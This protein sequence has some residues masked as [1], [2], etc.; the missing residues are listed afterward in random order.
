MTSMAVTT[1]PCRHRPARPAGKHCPGCRRGKVVDHVTAAGVKLPRQVVADAV[2]TVVAERPA[3][4]RS[5]AVALSSHPTALSVGAPPTVGLLVT[6]LIARGAALAVPACVVCARTGRPLTMTETGG[7]CQR[8][9]A[10]RNPQP[11]TRC[12][13]IKPVVGHTSDGQPICERCRRHERGHRPCG[14]CGITAS[15]AV[16]A[17]DGEPDV[18]VNCYRLPQ[19]ICSRCARRRPCLFADS[20]QP[21]CKPCAPRSTDAC[22]RCGRDRPPAVR[23]PEGPL[24]DTCYTTALRRRAHCARCGNLRRLVWPP[25]PDATTCTD[26]AGLPPSHTCADCGVE[27]KLYERNHCAACSLRRR[28]A[29]LLRGSNKEIPARFAG[30]HAAIV[31]TTAP[32]SALNWLRNGAGAAVL[33]EIAAG[34]LA[35]TH[36][37][38]DA[39]PRPQ[40]A[41][42]LRH[43]LVANGALPP[44]DEAVARTERWATD[45]IATIA[46]PED[47]RLAKAYTTWRVL[48]RLRRGAAQRPRPRTYTAVAH[49][50]LRTAVDFLAWLADHSL[51]LADCKQSDVDLWLET[52]PSAGSVRDFLLWAAEHHHCQALHVAPPPR[53]NAAT[54]DP[55]QRWEQITRLLHDENLDLTDRVAGCLLL[56]YGQQLS[57]IAMTTDQV[58]NHN[59]TVSIRFG[60]DAIHLPDK[61]GRA[62]LELAR[63]GRAYTGVGSPASRWLFPGGRPGKPI[64]ASQL[65]V[66]LRKLGI[67][68]LP[69]RRSSMIHLAAHVPAAVLADLLNLGPNTAV[70]WMHEAGA[71]WT[72]YAAELAHDDVPQ[73]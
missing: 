27:D 55:E 52:G 38:L 26:C 59:G 66:R 40:A 9:A 68:A 23:W 37:A 41:D 70:R 18:C 54:S 31:A 10:R 61:L 62:A 14:V 60:R 24:C 47:R 28:T 71:D 58:T 25:G 63:T 29:V 57:R 33:A 1:V 32:R 20:E 22:A 45:I 35:L 36:E 44:R 30:V 5:L 69:G 64:T 67:G 2:D 3:T 73:P 15:I 56:L 43:V 16:R 53:N 51:T 11:C 13:V 21:I 19:A 17:R 39:H 4:L 8:C 7:M 34:R 12:A 6:E 50:R 72:R 65:G 49:V 48:R 42:Y 46:R